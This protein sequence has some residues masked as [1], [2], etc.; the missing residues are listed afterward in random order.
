[1]SLKNKINCF[2]HV[3]SHKLQLTNHPV[4]VRWNIIGRC[5]NNCA[6]CSYHKIEKKELDKEEI[7]AVF[8]TLKKWGI[9][10]MSI[11]GGEP[12]LSKNF[13][14]IVDNCLKNNISPI[15]NTSGYNIENQLS[16]VKKLD[17]IQ[18]SID[19]PEE[20][21][22]KNRNAHT[23]KYLTQA[24]NI[25]KKHNI[26]LSLCCTLTKHNTNIKTID[27]LIDFAR[28][29]KTIIAFQPLKDIYPN[30]YYNELKSET[31]AFQQTINY[32][33][34]LKKHG[35]KTIRNTPHELQYISN[36]PVYKNIKCV[37]GKLFLIIQPDGSILGCDRTNNKQ[38][39]NLNIL[40][41]STE[42]ILAELQNISCNGCGFLGALELAELYD[43]NFSV[44]KTLVKL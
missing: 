24:I 36:W 10:R 31:T 38:L 6:Y 22:T 11:S 14:F 30:S 13:E 20:V 21:M 16:A 17:L 25:A 3:L 35:E 19:G 41:D 29:N 34:Q 40:S 18:L 37:A 12:L 44:L 2:L 4:A 8:A 7:L 39:L 43:L 1:M 5:V 32:L 23:F 27:Y 42:K 33:Y 26:K 9:C 15:I 28:T